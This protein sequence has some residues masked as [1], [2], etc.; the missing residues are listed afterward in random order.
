MGFKKLFFALFENKHCYA[1]GKPW[2]FFC[3]DCSAK[4][5]TYEPY[6]YACKKK[7]DNFY[8]HS[9]CTSDIPYIKNIIVLTRY[10]NPTIKKLLKHAKYY[11]K[12]HMY[13]EI[14][15]HNKDFFHKYI[16][17]DY[18]IFIPIPMHFLR[19]WRRWYNQSEIIA[20]ELSLICSI[21]IKNTC[22]RKIKYTSQQSRLWVIQRQKNLFGAFSFNKNM[23]LDKNTHIY[24]VDDV[25]SSASTLSECAKLLHQNGYENI[26]A[27]CLASD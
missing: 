14:I 27:V 12:K 13:H 2:H 9:K 26:S 18:S 23:S 8:I 15:S 24:L 17:A 10:R 25:I 5:K 4:L 3:W 21:P 1:C 19:K 22:L 11:K 16:T 20:K 7:S 6:C